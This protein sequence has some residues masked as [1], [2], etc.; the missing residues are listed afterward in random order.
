MRKIKIKKQKKK[1]SERIDKLAV[2]KERMKDLKNRLQEKTEEVTNND[3]TV[4]EYAGNKINF[5]INRGTDESIHL[6]NKYGKKSTIKTKENVS[7][8]IEKIKNIKTRNVKTK[9]NSLIKT[10]ENVLKSGN[11]IVKVENQALKGFQKQKHIVKVITKV[12]AKSIKVA[13]KTTISTIKNVV[14]GA[15][16]AMIALMA[17]GWILLV[18]VLVVGVVSLLLNSVFG[19]FFSNQ[20]TNDNLI[21]MQEVIAECNKEFSDKIQTIQNSNPHDD[22]ILEG[23]MASW[24][25]MLQIYSVKTSIDK[26]ILT[27]DKDKK[28]SLKEIFWEM[29]TLSSE[30]KEEEITERGITSN[31]LPTIVN[32]KVLHIKITNKS[33]QDMVMKYHFT[34]SQK[35]QLEEI[36]NSTYDSLWNEVIYG[37]AETGEYIYWRQKDPLW[38]DIKIGNTTSTIGDIGC[39]VTSIAILIEKSGANENISPFNPGVFVEELNKNNGFTESGSLIYSAITNV[40]PNFEYVGNINLR[41]KT[42]TEKL[43]IITEYFNNGYY[44]TVEVRGATKGNQHWVAVVGILIMML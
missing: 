28:D 9:A 44:L 14:V 39:L 40:I 8:G 20:K 6:A 5:V 2:S 19:I 31:E 34:F 15:K 37:T 23:E 13:A 35:Q 17:G 16:A 1:V 26:E 38:A 36:S 42:R 29:N 4:N 22:Y 18:A 21:T 10:T 24:K 43:N 32:K 25:D 27:I 33:L 7:K 30:V 41:E 3:T 12:S 11:K